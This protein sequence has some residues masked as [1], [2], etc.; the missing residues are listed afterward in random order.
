MSY[1]LSSLK[2]DIHTPCLN[3]EFTG[4]ERRGLESG[5]DIMRLVLR[6]ARAGPQRVRR[7]EGAEGAGDGGR[8]E[9]AWAR[10]G[11]V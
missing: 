3:F 5:C 8:G 7:R 6:I 2:K 11:E 10:A 9:G 1:F 4:S